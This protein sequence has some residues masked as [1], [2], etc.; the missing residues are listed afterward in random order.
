MGAKC[1][2]ILFEDKLMDNHGKMGQTRFPEGE[3]ALQ[4]RDVSNS[5]LTSAFLHELMHW[6]D[7]AYN[8]YQLNETQ[9]DA[10]AN[11]IHIFLDY[12]GVELDWE[13][14]E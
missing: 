8:G 3:I 14:I 10:L 2:T 4:K 1:V 5:S 7:H 6:I 13:D 11:G 12:L 9:T